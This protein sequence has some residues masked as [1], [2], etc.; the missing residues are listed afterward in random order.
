MSKGF[1]TDT[2]REALGCISEKLEA[3]ADE[4]NMLDAQLGD[5]DLG[6]SLVRGARAVAAEMPN[7]PEDVGMALLKCAQAFTRLSGSTYGTLLATGLMNA[8]KATKGKTEVAWTEVSPLLGNAMQAMAQR[9]GGQLG[10]KTVLDALDA[11]QRATKGLDDPAALVAAA[12][13]AVDE[14]LEQFR[15][16]PARQGRARIFGDQSVGKDDPGMVAFKHMVEA[17]KGAGSR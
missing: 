14:C 15:D 13:Q 5:G 3:S 11:V 1:T 2:L 12:D 8:A 7:L 10:D 4:L 16:K 17:L 9:G 6:V